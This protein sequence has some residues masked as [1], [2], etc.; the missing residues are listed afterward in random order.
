VFAQ[1]GTGIGIA[2]VEG[3]LIEANEALACMLGYTVTELHRYRAADFAHPSDRADIYPAYRELL[4]GERD[5]FRAEKR[6]FRKDGSELWAD[7]SFTLIRD[8]SCRPAYIVVMMHDVTERQRLHQR[9]RH[10]ARHD[11][12][13]QLPNRILF[14]DQLYEIFDAGEPGERIGLC[15]VDLDGFKAVNDSLG[16]DIGDELLVRLATRLHERLAPPGHLVARIGGDEFV[17]LV[18]D[19][20][21]PSDALAVAESVLD[22]VRE[23]VEIGGHQLRMTASIGVVEQ[24]LTSTDAASLMKAADV[25]LYQ[26]KSGGKNRWELFD[27]A[28]DEREITRHTIAATMPAGLANGVIAYQP[29]VE[30]ASGRTTGAEALVAWQHPRFGRL[31]ADR[32]IAL[33]DE[34][35]LIDQLGAWILRQACTDATAWGTPS[36]LV[37][38]DVTTR[39]ATD[40]RFVA[41]VREALD[42]AGLPPDRLRLE[43]NESV[44]HSFDEPALVENL[45][46]LAAIGVRLLIDGFG[47]GN[48]NLAAMRRLPV[49]GF[50]I[51]ESFIEA[52]AVQPDPVAAE[53]VATMIDFAGRL[54]L[55]VTASGIDTPDQLRHLRTLGCRTG[56][57]QVFGPAPEDLAG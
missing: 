9:L 37:S 11:P 25:T 29:I 8:E 40:P 16:H 28:R 44:G 18:A 30:L 3:N 31:D 27:A 12:L 48:G 55:D 15:Y 53:L 41:V 14:F 54:G 13:T 1:A 20:T 5:Q 45:R 39:Q 23:P 47:A 10:Q 19:C 36:F 50:K 38:V 57:G 6:F 26:A 24:P 33:A 42:A 4:A 56:Q 46:T 21:G 17:V 51:A 52:L 49:Q 43:L 2:D 7:M 34:T 35:G 32:F 22:L